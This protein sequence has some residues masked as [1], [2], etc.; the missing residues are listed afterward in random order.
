MMKNYNIVEKNYSVN[1]VLI[2]SNLETI[3]I[4]SLS[5]TRQEF[6]DCFNTIISMSIC[7][8]AI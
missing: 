2:N 6:I 3:Q 5:F 1:S 8:P 4:R 7:I